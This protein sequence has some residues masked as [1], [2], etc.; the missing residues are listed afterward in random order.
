M[1]PES[2]IPEIIEENRWHF[3]YVEGLKRLAQELFEK[4]YTLVR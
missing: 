2:A 4:G 3:Y 1:M